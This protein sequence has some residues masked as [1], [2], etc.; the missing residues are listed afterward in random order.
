MTK[1]VFCVRWQLWALGDFTAQ[2]LPCVVGSRSSASGSILDLEWL[3]GKVKENNPS[4][5]KPQ[6]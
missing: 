5:A 6:F 2:M 1:F 4:E 3:L